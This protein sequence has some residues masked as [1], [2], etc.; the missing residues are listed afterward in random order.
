ML[1]SRSFPPSTQVALFFSPFSAEN[2]SCEAPRM[3]MRQGPPS[4]H[5][6]RAV[7]RILICVHP[8]TKDGKE[9]K[10]KRKI[11]KPAH[12]AGQR[13]HIPAPSCFHC[14]PRKEKKKK[15]Q[16]ILRGRSLTALTDR[17]P[18]SE[19]VS[20]RR[21]GVGEAPE[22]EESSIISSCSYASRPARPPSVRASERPSVLA[23]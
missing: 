8:Q 20:V 1:L 6:C 23:A 2:R 9:Q 21:R 19:D 22:K 14:R 16:A 5:W 7:S 17:A 13:R 18:A 12:I 11:K 10:R 15:S 4:Q 3:D